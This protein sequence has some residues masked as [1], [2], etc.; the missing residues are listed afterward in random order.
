MTPVP[1]NAVVA[2]R[3]D[4][5][6]ARGLGHLAKGQIPPLL[7]AI[8]GLVMTGVLLFLGV[9]REGDPAVF[10]PAVVLLLAGPG[11][12]SPHS[13]RLDWLVPPIL[14]V[15]E[16]GFLAAVGFAA[17]ASPV[18]IYALLGALAFHHYDVVYRVR[19]R[20]YPPSWLGLAG[21]GWDGRMLFAAL[22]AYA[23]LVQAG[24]VLLAVWLW[25][26][27]AWESVTSWLA[28]PRSAESEDLGAD[29]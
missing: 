7:P 2:Y 1:R 24:Y 21:L 22:A 29:D 13:G 5:P 23:G 10:A 14:R 8:V 15:T 26:L 17:G 25:G 28:A 11:S 12:S 16:Y 4:G 6:V 3:D 19:Q 18:V 9:A 20:I 27:F